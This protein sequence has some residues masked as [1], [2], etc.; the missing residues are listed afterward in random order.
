M[1]HNNTCM[2]AFCSCVAIGN[3]DTV[4]MYNTGNLSLLLLICTIA[5]QISMI[6]SEQA[7][8]FAKKKFSL[9]VQ[10]T[11]PI[12]QSSPGKSLSETAYEVV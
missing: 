1:T 12:H 4:L 9:P 5:D 6:L 7:Y 3:Y 8:F 10:S 2:S 11:S